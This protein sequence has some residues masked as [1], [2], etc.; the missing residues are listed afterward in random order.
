MVTADASAALDAEHALVRQQGE[1][2]SAQV[3][4]LTEELATAPQRIAELDAK[5]TP[6]PRLGK[7]NGK[8]NVAERAEPRPPRRHRA[9]EH[10]QARRREEPSVGGSPD[11]D[12]DVPGLRSIGGI[13]AGAAPAAGGTRR[14]W[15]G[16]DRLTRRSGRG[17]GGGRCQPGRP[18]A[19]RRCGGRS[20]ASNAL[21]PTRMGR[22]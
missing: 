20:A 17:A 13:G 16:A 9:P 6:P 19:P 18:P 22:G 12:D 5:K 11:H 15:S 7:A 4:R 1:E 2:L 8:A 14:C 21:W 3:A 10:H